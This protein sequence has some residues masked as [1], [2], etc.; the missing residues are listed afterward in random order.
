MGMGH[1]IEDGLPLVILPCASKPCHGVVSTEVLQSR[2]VRNAELSNL[3]LE[4]RSRAYD[5]MVSM[6]KHDAYKVT[7]KVISQEEQ[8]VL[9]L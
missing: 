9:V 8:A 5:L 3:P 1:K 2:I 4:Q 7:S 6:S